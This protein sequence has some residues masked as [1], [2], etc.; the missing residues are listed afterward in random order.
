[1]ETTEQINLKLGI[2][3]MA[4]L[5]EGITKIEIKNIGRNITYSNPI[6]KFNWVVLDE[7][8]ENTYKLTAGMPVVKNLGCD[9]DIPKDL[10]VTPEGYEIYFLGQIGTIPSLIK[11]PKKNGVLTWKEQ[12]SK[13]YYR[14]AIVKWM[15]RQW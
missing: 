5:Y 11:F 13:H 1:M 10:V 7:H 8:P 4:I 12:L 6:K 9:D 3:M 15:V 14:T 2:P